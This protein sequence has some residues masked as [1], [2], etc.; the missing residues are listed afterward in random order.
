M[1]G[2][3][4]GFVIAACGLVPVGMVTLMLSA[5]NTEAS[6]T[7]SMSALVNSTEQAQVDI[8]EVVELSIQEV[9]NAEAIA[10]SLLIDEFAP[11]QAIRQRDTLGSMSIYQAMEVTGLT[12]EQINYSIVEHQSVEGYMFEYDKSIAG[13]RILTPP[14]TT[15]FPN[16][17]EAVVLTGVP[18]ELIT[19]S[20]TEQKTVEG[21]KFEYEK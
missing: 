18:I 6:S 13:I 10:P 16:L 14:D 17:E 7:Q 4:K 1:T 5:N 20:I 3:I 2:I 11:I 19:L 9:L 12:R 8:S 15:V 21:T